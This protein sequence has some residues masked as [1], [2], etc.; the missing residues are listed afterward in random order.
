MPTIR[1]L[2][3]QHRQRAV[4]VLLPDGLGADCERP[5]DVRKQAYP[6]QAAATPHGGA[7][8][9]GHRACPQRQEGADFFPDEGRQ[10]GDAAHA[11]SS[12]VC[13]VDTKISSSVG[14][15]TASASGERA[16]NNASTCS[17]LPVTIIS[18]SPP[19]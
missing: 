15:S 3:E 10:R 18:I 9:D 6:G 13:T 2:C 12:R 17:A 16:R 1:G 7:G 11:T 19:R 14:G 8:E 5:D 4:C